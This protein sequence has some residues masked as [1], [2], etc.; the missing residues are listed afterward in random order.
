MRTQSTAPRSFSTV[1]LAWCTASAVESWRWKRPSYSARIHDS[2]RLV[3]DGPQA[4]DDGARAGHLECAT[5][6][7]DS[8]ASTDLTHARV[9][10]REHG[11]FDAAQIKGCDFLGG[12]DAVVF[13]R[14]GR[15]AAVGAGQRQTREMQRVFYDGRAGQAADAAGIWAGGGRAS[16]TRKN[17]CVAR[18]STRYGA[19]LA[20]AQFPKPA[21]QP[22]PEPIPSAWCVLPTRERAPELLGECP[23]RTG[24]GDSGGCRK[25]NR[26]REWPRSHSLGLQP[27][28]R[29]QFGGRIAQVRRTRV[30]QLL[31]FPTH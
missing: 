31:A 4:H 30:H 12:E 2:R 25:P 19:R 20:L 27:L 1:R 15:C 8:L 24:S 9:A 18:C 26:L 6:S 23:P 21:G 28:L 7:E 3:V 5:E 22:A 29:L 14:T 11:P 16:V 10:G 13:V 17:P